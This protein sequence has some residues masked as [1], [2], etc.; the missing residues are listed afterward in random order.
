MHER[1]RLDL[2]HQGRVRRGDFSGRLR[3]VKNLAAFGP[4]PDQSRS[5]ILL[6]TVALE[7]DDGHGGAPPEFKQCSGTEGSQRR[8]GGLPVLGDE[9]SLSVQ[10]GDQSAGSLREGCRGEQ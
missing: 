8:S 5:R 9:Q 2:T 6:D 1:G 4:D 7:K 3:P 10:T